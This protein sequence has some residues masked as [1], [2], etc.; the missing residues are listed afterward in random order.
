MCGP[1]SSRRGRSAA[2]NTEEMQALAQQLLAMRF[3]DLPVRDRRV[4]EKMVRR[5]KVSSDINR[6]LAS[7]A[8]FGERI[9]DRVAAFG[10]SWTFIIGFGVALVIWVVLNSVVLIRWG[11]QFDPYPY[12]FLNLVLSMLAA[13]QAPVIMMSQ[14]RQA[15]RDR[16]AAGH[17]YEVNLK[18]ELEIMRLHEKMDDLRGRQIEALLASQQSQI[19]LLTALI[20]QS[21]DGGRASG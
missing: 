16:L 2:D 11:D 17:D 12:I 5:L 9:A 15:V 19:A 1:H 20:T 6:E 3:E 13:I 7:A 14:N 21:R 4:L 10:G 18:A 8:T